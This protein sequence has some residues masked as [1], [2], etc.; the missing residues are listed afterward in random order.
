M[1]IEI[2]SMLD[3]HHVLPRPVNP[4]KLAR[5]VLALGSLC[6]DPKRFYGHDLVAALQH[7]EPTQVFNPNN[8]NNSNINNNHPNNQQNTTTNKPPQSLSHD[9]GSAAA[10]A[11]AGA[12]SAPGNGN[13]GNNGNQQQPPSSYQQ[14]PPPPLHQQQSNDRKLLS[15]QLA[16]SELQ[17][18]EFA[19]TTLAVC[20]SA[21]HVRKRQIRR[22]LDI[23]SGVTDQSVGKCAEILFV[24]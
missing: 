1:E 20:S 24:V 15:S 22:L 19:L 17:D 5:Y 10:A 12:A 3:K 6:K 14:H 2:L 8:P 18:Q 9:S 21:A 7:H 13:N 16:V 23:A 11:A 4:D